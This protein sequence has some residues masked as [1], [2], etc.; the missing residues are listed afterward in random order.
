MVEAA[1]QG[2]AVRVRFPPA[3]LRLQDDFGKFV[4]C[5][6]GKFVVGMSLVLRFFGGG[7]NEAW[8]RA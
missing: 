5:L 4:I 2:A 7:E 8:V 3:T 1:R 6:Y